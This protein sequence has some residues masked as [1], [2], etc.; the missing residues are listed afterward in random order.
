M[1]KHLLSSVAIMLALGA[2][3]ADQ[4]EVAIDADDI[5]GVVTGPKGPEAGVWVIAETTDLPTRFRR[6]VVT[7]DQGRYV[8]PDLPAANY[9]VW[10]RGYGL[11]DSAKTAAAPG[12][13]VHITAAAAPDAATAAQ[14]Y[15]AI[16]WYSM[17]KIPAKEEF[18][19][20]Q[21][22][23]QGQWLDV[24]KTDGCVTCH[25]LGS[26]ATRTLSPEL[27]N[28]ES[29]AD[30]W[31]R[32]LSSGQ[33]G[34]NMTNSIARLDA[35][36]AIAHFADW[37]DRIA[38]GELP[39]AQPE[40]PQGL[41]RNAVITIWDWSRPTAYLHD[42]IATDKRNP[43]VNAYGPIYG[44]PE[45][46]TDMIP[47]LDPKTHTATE[48]QAPVRD[49]NT[50]SAA[51]TPV[52]MPSVYFGEQ[53]I[54]DS[55]ANL[56]NPMLDG[57]GR[58]W[59]T[60]RIRAPEN[61]AFCQKGSDHPSA[62]LFPTERTGRHL[63]VY[64]PGTKEFKLVDTCYSTHH[65]QFDKNDILWTS[66]GGPVLGWLD[67][68]KFL[69]TGD[70]AAAQ[71]WTPLVVDTNG[72]GKR[73]EGYVQPD[74]DV[75]PKKDKRVMAGFYGVAPNPADGSIW[76]SSL[77]YPGYIIRVEN[78]TD[79]AAALTEIYSPPAPGYSPRGMD[80]DKN[81][82]VWAPLASGHFA[83]FDRRKC[84][85]PLNGPEAATGKLCPEGW[86]LYPFPGPQFAGL[87]GP[88]SAESSYYSWVD[89]HNTLGLGEDV[90][91]ATGNLNDSLIV[92]HDGKMIQLRVP[93]P[94]NFYMKGLDG[95]IDDPAIGWKGRGIWTTTG[96][97]T[98]MHSE[99]GK[100]GRPKVAH[101]Q[102]RPDPLAH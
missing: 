20:G 56:H 102:M 34:V 89:Q 18:P 84:K 36:K 90:P 68:K 51:E 97:R 53:A 21:A 47:I 16:Y 86:T 65:L 82:V 45:L 85:G 100:G 10:A 12:K 73:D 70:A 30:A 52:M 42:E 31:M 69:D 50:P 95:R 87:E 29:S 9:T 96:D 3:G 48:I 101:F 99:D 71:G 80:I 35:T 92:M 33:A 83:S 60:H 6:I 76:G 2:C 14:F 61:P 64:D 49:E 58:V 41:E 5:G 79:P 22:K 59:F 91:M 77:G 38:A 13:Q 66:G 81:G 72:N 24:V 17:M 23:D 74:Q 88:G 28:F 37:T 46:S 62:K 39:H 25:Q 57:E 94:L 32:R 63:S 26:K 78:A 75:D 67:K 98:P 55:K 11:V 27:G 43:T 44:A 8:V 93:Y 40:R 4:P 19:L 54:W 7:D 15:P 1:R